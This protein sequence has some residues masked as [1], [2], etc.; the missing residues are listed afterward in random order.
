MVGSTFVIPDAGANKKTAKIASYFG[1]S[2]FIRAD[3][4]RNLST[5]DIL[6]TVV[7]GDV[8]G[9]ITIV[10][11]LCDGGKTFIELAKVLKQKGAEKINLYVTHGIFSKGTYPLYTAGIDY[12]ITTNS[13]GEWAV[14]DRWFV[15]DLKSFKY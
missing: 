5:G 15:L 4:L 3:K 2:S 13:R 14:D 8:V 1:H 11:D 12:I 7:Y 6:E 9:N 10:D